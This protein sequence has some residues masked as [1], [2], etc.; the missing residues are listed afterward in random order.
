MRAFVRVGVGGAAGGRNAWV[1]RE[2]AGMREG[3]ENSLLSNAGRVPPGTLQALTH[4]EVWALLSVI[5]IMIL[6]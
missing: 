4:P 1:P 3:R 5:I 2:P 6:Y